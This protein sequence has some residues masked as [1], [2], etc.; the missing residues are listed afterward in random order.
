MEQYQTLGLLVP[1][2]IG[3]I[4]LFML[5]N[6]HTQTL[7][8][9]AFFVSAFT[10][11]HTIYLLTQFNP[12]GGLQ[13]EF[14]MIWIWGANINFHI[15]IDGISMPLVLLTTML[16]PFIILSARE[17]S[18]PHAFFG[19]VLLMETALIGVFVARDAV[20]Y[21]LF[22]EAALIPVYFLAAIWGGENRIKVTF[23]FFIYTVFGSLFMLIA[24]IVLYQAAG[25]ADYEAF[26]NP[27]LRQKLNVNPTAQAIL[28]WCLF[29]A[30]AIKMPIFP[31]HTWQPD[32]Y[33]ESPTTAT[34][35]LSGI[36]L[37]MG[38]Y[39]LFR[40]LLPV[41]PMATVGAKDV[42]IILSVIGIV[43]GAIIAIQQTDMKRLVAYSSFSHVGL[44]AAGVFC[45][46]E[47]GLQGT[48]IQML[49]H[50]INIVG[51][52]Y[53]LDIIQN[54]TNTREIANL[55]G[56]TQSAPALTIYFTI[57]MLG[58][59]ALPLTNGF[60]GEFLL[61]RAVFQDN[62]Y[63]GAIAG[64]TIIFGAVYMLRMY[65]KIMFGEKTKYTENI[66]DV[67]L[68]ES[69]VLFPLCVMVFVMGLF[70]NLFLQLSSPAVLDL[71]KM[72]K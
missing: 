28:F 41:L 61:L 62:M 54:R 12:A 51:L 46:N 33:T 42:I 50:G 3:S 67:T 58:S 2:L 55:G 26:T 35:L 63:L 31:F 65:Q 59:V 20:L 1:P 34:M 43:Y 30:F 27:A 32:T 22:W 52:F 29:I 18:Y 40:W 21:Y 72:I 25:S 64:L 38:V 8:W 11:S 24:L 5:R 17:H 7:K 47:F 37:K 70:P 13:F 69:L 66:Q 9:V 15:G 53:V 19:L 48:M 4:V 56:I 10:F 6:L 57:L 60:V 14:N 45:L 39:S 16:C 49:A 23:K 44:M 68:Q 71:L 36:M